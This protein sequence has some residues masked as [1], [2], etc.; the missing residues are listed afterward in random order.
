M[1]VYY[2]EIVVGIAP[3]GMKIFFLAQKT[4]LSFIL[5]KKLLARPK[6]ISNNIGI[7]ELFIG[8]EQCKNKI[9]TVL[10]HALYK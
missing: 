7:R 3:F 1:K 10:T 4:N 6:T 9:S 8:N 2:N 5:L